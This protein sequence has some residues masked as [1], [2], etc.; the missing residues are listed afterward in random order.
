MNDNVMNF[1]NETQSYVLEATRAYLLQIN[2]IPLLTPEEEREIVLKVAQGDTKAREKLIESNLRLVVSIAKKYLTRTRIPLLDLIQEGTIGLSTAA[3]KFDPSLEYRFSTYATWWI[4][5]AIS[6]AV[7][8]QSRTIR[9][10][11]HIIEQ[12]NKL[13]RVTS[14]LY[15]ELN[16]EPSAQEIADRMELPL[17]KIKE[18]Q[19]IVK[20][21]VSIDQSINDEDDATIGDLVADE[22]ENDNT[23]LNDLF[24][25]HVSKK[26]QEVLKTLDTREADVIVRRYGLSN[27]RPQTL[28]EIGASFGLTKERIR[29]IEN[30]ALRKLRHPVRTKMLKDCIEE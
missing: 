9:L 5:Q 10:P 1:E 15:Q 13:G 12:L 24:K 6:R 2:R 11:V 21:P 29:Q 25:E 3:D 20:E 8:E 4:K 7:I 19:A 27:N 18:L 30:S 26:V 23:A 28:E 22:S 16:R 17:K 14:E